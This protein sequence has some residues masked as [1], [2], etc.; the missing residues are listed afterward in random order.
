MPNVDAADGVIRTTLRGQVLDR[1]RT[2]IVDWDLAPASNIGE[3]DLCA[4][5][6][7]SRT[8]LREALLGLEAEGLL[9]SEAGRGF[10][11]AALSIDEARELYPLIWTLESLAVE[12]GRPAVTPALETLAAR[13]RAARTPPRAVSADGAWHEALIAA[14]RCPRTAAI[15]RRLRT[16]AA[17]YEY[18]YFS[19]LAS[20]R[21]SAGQHDRICRALRRGDWR[22][23]AATLRRNWEQGLDVILQGL[24]TDEEK[25]RTC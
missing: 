20:I 16:A 3:R 15:L 1:V 10:F 24:T 4:R 17:R 13:F 19:D 23:A 21:A 12:Q 11:V 14:C 25:G 8:P 5:L 7:V 2:L 22:E 9:R 6:G 18:R